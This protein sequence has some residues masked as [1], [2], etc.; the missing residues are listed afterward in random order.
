MPL[1]QHDLEMF[2]H[3]IHGMLFRSKASQLLQLNGESN[4]QWAR[5]LKAYWEA[6]IEPEVWKNMIK[7]ARNTNYDGLADTIAKVIA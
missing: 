3:S 2:V 5:R 1:P 6:E 4:N 7:E